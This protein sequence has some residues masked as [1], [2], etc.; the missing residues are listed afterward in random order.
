MTRKTYDEIATE[1]EAAKAA[2]MIWNVDYKDLK[3]AAN[4]MVWREYMDTLCGKVSTDGLPEK[5]QKLTYSIPHGTHGMSGWLKKARAS[6]C[7]GF[8]PYVSFAERWA[9]IEVGFNALKPLVQKGRK[10][11]PMTP[12]KLAEI[13]ADAAARRTCQICGRKIL[14]DADGKLAHHGYERPYGQG[15]HTA[16]CYGA[17]ELKFEADRTVLGRFIETVMKPQLLAEQCYLAGWKAHT[18]PIW[19]KRSKFTGSTIVSRQDESEAGPG[20]GWKRL[21]SQANPTEWKRQM[22]AQ[23]YEHERNVRFLTRDI[24]DQQKRYDTWTKTED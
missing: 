2:G 17:R 15:F 10:V 6:N 12:E 5:V 13:E 16:S 1:I 23:I 3:D 8:A 21:D 22:D 20:E 11:I 24:A 14:P 4:R 9:P 7:E 18:G 19:I